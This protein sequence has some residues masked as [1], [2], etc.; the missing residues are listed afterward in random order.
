MGWGDG[1][2]G[3]TGARGL[4]GVEDDVHCEEVMVMKGCV[5][6]LYTFSGVPVKPLRHLKDRWGSFF[7]T[8]P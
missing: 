3:A 6:L 2:D 4:E 7:N 8:S 5:V 1:I